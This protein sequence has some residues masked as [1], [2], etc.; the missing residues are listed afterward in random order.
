MPGRRHTDRF[1][2]IE[3][4]CAVEKIEG[5]VAGLQR[6]KKT[7]LKRSGH[8]LFLKR[9]HSHIPASVKFVYILITHLHRSYF[10]MTIRLPEKHKIRTEVK[11][12]FI[13]LRGCCFCNCKA[14]LYLGKKGMDA[15]F[16]VAP[17]GTKAKSH[18]LHSVVAPLCIC[19]II[20]HS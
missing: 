17:V 1:N 18:F 9:G 2:Y 7:L 20:L 19:S 13:I 6:R 10:Y 12:T 15:H 16:N 8:V 14:C 3:E 4:R 11:G 5:R